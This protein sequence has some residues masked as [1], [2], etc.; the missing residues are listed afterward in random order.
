MPAQVLWLKSKFFPENLF[1]VGSD[2]RSSQFLS[3][4]R[5]EDLDTKK[6]VPEGEDERPDD[7]TKSSLER[8][9]ESLV[10]HKILDLQVFSR[11][12]ISLMPS[13][14]SL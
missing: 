11:E 5:G 12:N 7:L 14:F 6:I 2:L 1:S 9:S 3:G 8:K 13:L 10:D 4:G